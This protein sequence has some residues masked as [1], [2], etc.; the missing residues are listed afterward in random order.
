MW[1]ART[2]KSVICA[3]EAGKWV[4]G[5]TQQSKSFFLKLCLIMW[6]LQKIYVTFWDSVPELEISLCRGQSQS[7][8]HFKSKALW[9]GHR[10]VS[11]SG[12]AVICR[13]ELRQGCPVG[14]DRSGPRNYKSTYESKTGKVLLYSFPLI[15]CCL[16]I[17]V[18]E[19]SYTIMRTYTV[20]CFPAP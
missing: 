12:L 20:R 9:F 6:K 4:R 2:A 3:L 17:V 10:D 11:W 5:E 8:V 18:S 1:N 13:A 7:R 15:L 14:E 19:L 16:V